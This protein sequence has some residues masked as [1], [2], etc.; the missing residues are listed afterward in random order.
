MLAI[1]A[2]SKDS[3]ARLSASAHGGK[4]ATADLWCACDGTRPGFARLARVGD[5]MRGWRQRSH[6]PERGVGIGR[7]ITG[8]LR[9]W[10]DRWATAKVFVLRPADGN[11]DGER[12]GNRPGLVHAEGSGREREHLPRHGRLRRVRPP[13]PGHD[14]G[15]R[16]RRRNCAFLRAALRRHGY[17]PRDLS[18]SRGDC[19]THRR[20]S[21]GGVR[22]WARPDEPE[23]R[24]AE[25]QQ[26]RKRPGARDQPAPLS[27][28]QDGVASGHDVPAPDVE[29]P[30]R[31]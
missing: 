17:R 22:S 2:S 21:H 28:R 24:G 5:G 30:L 19:G 20:R 11:G 25:R 12:L 15:R 6:D 27:V 4:D 23:R 1:T 16:A 13:R 26:P 10:V 14:H 8:V 7:W 29:R 3:G 9:Q 31:G 18:R